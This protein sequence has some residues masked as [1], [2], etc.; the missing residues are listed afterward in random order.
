MQPDQKQ[1]NACLFWEMRLQNYLCVK[2]L[3]VKI[4]F[5]IFKASQKAITLYGAT[6]VISKL[7]RLPTRGNWSSYIFWNSSSR[8]HLV[9]RFTVCPW[10][11][12]YLLHQ[13]MMMCSWHKTVHN[14]LSKL[15]YINPVLKT[16]VI[17][18]F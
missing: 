1:H 10:L 11:N 13:W 12:T 15:M 7:H 2:L 4:F 14:T 9:T 16:L 18:M 17:C 5:F 3:I 8:Y 6:T